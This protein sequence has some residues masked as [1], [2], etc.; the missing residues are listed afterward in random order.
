[1]HCSLLKLIIIIIIT[2]KAKTFVN[3]NFSPFRHFIFSFFITFRH[4][5]SSEI[6]YV[7]LWCVCRLVL[8]Q[9]MIY[10][11]N[12]IEPRAWPEYGDTP[13]TSHAISRANAM[14]FYLFFIFIFHSA[15]LVMPLFGGWLVLLACCLR[16]IRGQNATFSIPRCSS[17]HWD[18]VK[19]A[20]HMLKA[21]NH[22]CIRIIIIKSLLSARAYNLCSS[23]FTQ[24]DAHRSPYAW[25]GGFGAL[26]LLT[27]NEKRENEKKEEEEIERKSTRELRHKLDTSSR[28]YFIVHIKSWFLVFAHWE[29]HKW[30]RHRLR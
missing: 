11:P 13:S 24:P 23:E 10:L 1:M 7:S 16:I 18:S 26:K 27:P 25:H 21:T 3:F 15:A 30:Q 19:N 6:V 29:L 14:D 4:Y 17:I 9:E 12:K 5:I 20:K 28:T 22:A 8:A 2:V